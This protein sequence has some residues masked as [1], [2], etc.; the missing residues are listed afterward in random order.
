MA[1]FHSK[2]VFQGERMF[3][4][5]YQ[6]DLVSMYCALAEANTIPF[7]KG[8]CTTGLPADI[9]SDEL[10]K[11]DSERIVD[12]LT[13]AFT[14]ALDGEAFLIWI[15]VDSALRDTEHRLGI[16]NCLSH[17]LTKFALLPYLGPKI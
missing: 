9:Q 12:G 11:D 14:T 4:L 10:S 15:P 2:L 17:G 13:L 5:A 8:F 6:N 16:A 1:R 3:H 7:T